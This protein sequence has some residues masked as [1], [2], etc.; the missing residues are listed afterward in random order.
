MFGA[1]NSIGTR[2]V[3]SRFQNTFLTV[4]SVLIYI[5]YTYILGLEIDDGFF[6]KTIPIEPAIVN[7]LF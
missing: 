6:P 3:I 5:I 1:L 7:L 4:I 2:V